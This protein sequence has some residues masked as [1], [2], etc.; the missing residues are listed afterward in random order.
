VSWGGWR[1]TFLPRLAP[2]CLCSRVCVCVCVCVFLG[3]GLFF[4]FAWALVVGA[5]ACE[6]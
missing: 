5:L 3:F 4:F 1:R 6:L 2:W